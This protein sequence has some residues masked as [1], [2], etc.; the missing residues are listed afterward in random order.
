MGVKVLKKRY[1]AGATCE[2]IVWRVSDRIR[3]IKTAEPRIRF[4]NEEERKKHRHEQGMR[5]HA[6]S[7][8]ENFAPGD[9]YCTPTF[10]DEYEVHTFEEAKKI[11]KSFHRCLQR[12]FPNAVF[13]I[14]MGRGK[15]TSRI[16]F[17]MV[18][19]GIPLEFIKKKWIYGEV[20]CPKTLREH[21]YY[22]NIDCGSDYT[23][24][25]NYLYN[26]WSE[27]IGGQHYSRTKNERKP[28]EEPAVEVHRNYSEKCPPIAPKGYTLVQTKATKYGF[29]YYKYVKLPP[30]SEK[31]REKTTAVER[32]D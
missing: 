7:F 15:G 22:D 31:V 29:F 11:R 27:E 10:S 4:K 6:R 25:A 9:L 23:G 3:D 1:F 14:Y 19:K 30:G 24:L 26:H 20:R 13:R 2:Q 8:N 18:S 5:H 32:F 16:H 17:H 21:N 12:K 28:E